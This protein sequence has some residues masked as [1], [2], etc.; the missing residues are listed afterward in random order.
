M[1]LYIVVLYSL[2]AFSLI[3]STKELL[4]IYHT[5]I[6]QVFIYTTLSEFLLSTS[7]VP[8]PVLG[9]CE[10]VINKVGKQV[11]VLTELMILSERT[12]KETRVKGA[13][14]NEK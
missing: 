2:K 7:C 5:N 14:E 4:N 12:N 8:C 13:E 10:I 11:S 6:Y 3:H 9:T 1:I